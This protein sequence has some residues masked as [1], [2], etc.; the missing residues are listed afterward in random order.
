VPVVALSVELLEAHAFTIPLARGLA[1]NG[2]LKLC[3]KKEPE[4][5]ERPAFDV[6][7]VE[8]WWPC[9]KQIHGCRC[10]C[11]HKVGG[12]VIHRYPG[13]DARQVQVGPPKYTHNMT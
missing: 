6:C 2:D 3:L 4:Q 12:P 8:P 13:P 10:S 11:L 9:C 5:A 7:K 1:T